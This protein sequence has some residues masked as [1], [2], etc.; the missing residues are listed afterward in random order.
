MK[1]VTLRQIKN[2]I[3]RVDPTMDPTDDGYDVA[4]IMLAALVVG[5]NIRRVAR[6][7]G[8]TYR[9]VTTIGRRLRENGIWRG[10]RT[11]CEWGDKENGGWSFLL[12]VNVGLGYMERA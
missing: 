1:T 12:E 9:K 11:V 10:G 2:Q 3:R 4:I 8:L 5:S 7:T 6:F